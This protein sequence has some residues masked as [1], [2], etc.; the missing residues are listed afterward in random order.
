MRPIDIVGNNPFLP[1]VTLHHVEDAMEVANAILEGGLSVIEVTLRSK[2]GLEAIRK[3]V[4]EKKDIIVG[5]GTVTLPSQVKEVKEAGAAFMVSPGF[6]EAIWREAKRYDIPW[7]P[8]ASTTTEVMAIREHGCTRVKFFPA[9]FFGGVAMLRNW[10]SFFPEMV[11]IPTGGITLANLHSYAMG[12][13]VGCVGGSWLVPSEAI[14]KKQW[15]D[16]ISTIQQSLSLI[17]K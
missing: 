15:E 4:K 10:E 8:G 14:A 12:N 6:N 9:E 3:L 13:N 1:L 16:I 2:Q 11:F 7:I 17:K 5:A